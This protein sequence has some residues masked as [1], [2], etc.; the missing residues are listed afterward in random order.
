MYARRFDSRG[1]PLGNEFRVNSVT[2]GAQFLTSLEVDPLGGFAVT[3]ASY[4]PTGEGIGIFGRQYSPNGTPLGGEF[5][6]AP[7]NASLQ[8]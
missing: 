6:I 1:E 8:E 4:A 5:M 3:W 2:A 7:L